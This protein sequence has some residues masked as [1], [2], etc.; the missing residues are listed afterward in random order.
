MITDIVGKGL[1]T[2]GLAVTKCTH[3]GSGN[4]PS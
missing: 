1:P 2:Y 3:C 4:L